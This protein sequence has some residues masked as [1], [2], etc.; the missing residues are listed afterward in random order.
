MAG[1][2]PS[3]NSELAV[4]QTGHFEKTK[5]GIV[6]SEWN[7]PI[8]NALQDACMTTLINLGIQ[9][10]HIKL[11]KVPGAYE[12]PLAA[13]W[14]L[15]QSYVQGVICLGCVIKGDTKHDEY[16]NHAIAGGIMNLS[17]RY[18]K[19]V[20]FGV[21]TTKNKKQAEERSGGKLGNKGEES[22]LALIRMLQLHDNIGIPSNKKA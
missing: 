12:L 8:T 1:I 4:I 18:S 17:L 5:I 6:V 19:P 16:I 7:S 22:A 20:I 9:Q 3:A 13:K 11:H 2:L 10:K 15:D 21:L 14:L